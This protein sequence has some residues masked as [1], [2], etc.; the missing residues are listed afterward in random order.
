MINKMI[1]LSSTLKNVLPKEHMLT[2]DWRFGS[3]CY[4]KQGH[5]KPLLLIH[6]MLPGSSAFEWHEI[7]SSLSLSHTVYTI[8]LLGFG[9]SDKPSITYTNYLYVQLLTDFIKN[10]IGKRTDIIAAGSSSSIA[11]MTCFNDSSLFDRI[12]LLNPDSI[13]KTNQIP[14][15]RAKVLKFLIELPV[16]GTFTYNIMVSRPI[17]KKEFKNY[18]LKKTSTY[19][20]QMEDAYHEAA[21]LG[22]S[23][24]RY[25]FSSI[26]GNY[27]NISISHKLCQIDNSIFIVG[28]EKEKDIEQTISDYTELNPATEYFIIENSKH[29]PQ[30]EQPKELIK[31]CNIFFV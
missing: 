17:L 12:M 2:Y 18:Y 7:A 26:Q 9:R 30:L 5:G 21:H 10:V 14:T 22:N 8:E 23:V 6:D 24:A 31:L 16:I 20:K 13:L 4:K 29:L 11:I 27:T 19:T 1:F 15:K 3:V 25:I 28:G